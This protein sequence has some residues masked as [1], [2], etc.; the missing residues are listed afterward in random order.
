[1]NILAVFISGNVGTPAISMVMALAP[2]MGLPKM[3]IVGMLSAMFGT[4]NRTPRGLCP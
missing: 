2:K 3:D 1:M 4:P